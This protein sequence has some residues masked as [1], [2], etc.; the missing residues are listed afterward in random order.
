MRN[1]AIDFVQV[2]YNIQDREVEKCI[3][4]PAQGRGVAVIANWPV[5]GLILVSGV[6][7]TTLVVRITAWH[8]RA[9]SAMLT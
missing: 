9:I 4:P 2:T 7:I 1:H 6:L 5:Q 8:G 3:L